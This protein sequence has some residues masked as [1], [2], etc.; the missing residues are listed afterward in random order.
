VYHI[1]NVELTWMTYGPAT[2]SQSIEVA[3][4]TGLPEYFVQATP[5]G[6]VAR[7]IAAPWPFPRYHI[8]NRE[9]FQMTEPM[10]IKVMWRTEP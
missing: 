1:L 5:S 10:P 9:P 8:M 6:D 7:P 2:K 4:M 3:T